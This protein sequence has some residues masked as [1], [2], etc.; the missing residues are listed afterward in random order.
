MSMVHFAI[1]IERNDTDEA[2]DMFYDLSN[3]GFTASFFN[4]SVD[5][6]AGSTRN[7]LQHLFD[8]IIGK[9][10][11]LEVMASFAVAQRSASL[12]GQEM[13]VDDFVYEK[14]DLK[15]TISKKIMEE[16]SVC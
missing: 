10:C 4:N 6:K 7:F 12:I 11:T 2:F 15:I 9:L 8:K 16:K 5:Y 13:I 14:D 1:K 3:R